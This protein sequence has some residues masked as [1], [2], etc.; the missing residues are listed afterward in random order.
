VSE[1]NSSVNGTS[2]GDPFLTT[3]LHAPPARPGLVPR[4]HLTERLNRGL[5]GPGDSFVRRV[6]L[7]CAPAGFGKTTLVTQWLS[8]APRP[9]TWLSLDEGDNDPARFF[10]YLVAALQAVDAT[11]GQGAQA[12]LQARRQPPTEALLTDLIND[13]A[14][15]PAPLAL[16]LDDYHVIQTLSIH[17]QLS[18]LVEHQPPSLHLVIISREDPPLPLARL[19]ARGHTAEI[20]QDDLRFGADETD[21]LL[22]RVMKLQLSPTEVTALHR[23]T[24]GWIAGLQLAAL[25]LRD[26]DDVREFVDS[27]TGSHRYILDYLIEEVF[28]RAPDSVRDFLLKTS[29]LDRFTASLCDAVAERDDSREMLLSLEQANLFIVPLDESRQWYRYHRLFADLL[30]QQLRRAEPDALVPELHRRASRWYE[31]EGLPG[32]AVR[33]ALAASDWERAAG[34]ILQVE[35]AMLMRGEVV[36]LLG[37]LRA[38]PDEALRR[39]PQLTMSYSWALILTGQL[40][41]AEST[42]AA[43]ERVAQAIRDQD[44]QGALLA[45]IAAAQAFIARTRGDDIRTIKLSQRALSLLPQENLS[46]RSIVALNLG[47]AHWSSGHLTEAERALRE[48]EHAARRSRN[49]YARLTALG[50][51]GTVQAAQGRLHEG[52]EW[53]REAIRVGGGSPPTA[54]ARDTLGALLYEWDDLEAAEK[55]LERGMELGARSGNVEIQI[56][57][58]RILARLR[59]ARGDAEGALDALREA[60]KLARETDISPLMR[61]RNA[62]CHVQIALAHGD[63]PMAKRWAEHVTMDADVSRFYPLLGLTP[64][65]LLLAKNEKAAAADQLEAWHETAVAAGWQFGAIEVRALQALAAPTVA[66]ALTFLADALA[67]AEAEGYVRTFVDKGEPMER[68]LRQA[69]ERGLAPDYVQRLLGAF[70]RPSTPSRRGS[71]PLVEPLSE[72]ELEVLQQLAAHKMNQEIAQMLIISVN[73]VKT[74]LKNIYGKLGVHSRQE[75]VTKASDLD[76]LP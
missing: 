37:W 41:E 50:F 25:S 38:L 31:A 52:A 12:T 62:A 23:R 14:A 33:H 39:H 61:A 63:L 49:D 64:A 71:Q 58:C 54:L 59:H 48:A 11:I 29:I 43:A 68:L 36:T 18:F 7:I 21:D 56:G 22:R 69:G 4:P 72:R 45:D 53:L 1:R 16:V 15:T 32:D 47:I 20:R 46:G 34:L 73:T 6:T 27:F 51:L 75:A 70:K 9:F 57:G 13:I 10:T 3:K 44:T 8:S 24:E 19:R 66:E 55:Q 17:Q 40:D 60:H 35:E 30:N 5:A 65:R 42:L 67:L 26:R 2:S 76:L 74:H 28:Q